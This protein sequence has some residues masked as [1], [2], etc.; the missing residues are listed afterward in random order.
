MSKV[1]INEITLTNIGAAIRERTGKTDLIAPGDMPAEIRGIIGGS[2]PVIQRLEI[3]TNGTYNVYDGVDGF[4]PVVVNVP[5]DGGPPSSAFNISGRSSYRFANGG[6]DWFITQY[7]NQI[8]TNI[9][10]KADHMFDG[11]KVEIP[12][13]INLTG[14]AID[15]QY[16]VS[17]FGGKIAPMI[18]AEY[19]PIDMSYMF[20]L[21]KI[22]SFPEGYGDDWDWSYLETLTGYQGMTSSMFQ[23]CSK[24]KNV[25]EAL[26]SHG[27][28]ALSYNYIYAYGFR[29]CYCLEKVNNLYVYGTMTSNNFNYT[30]DQCERLKDFTFKTQDSG[31]PF[32]ANWKG[33]VIDL[34]T[35]GFGSSEKTYESGGYGPAV[36]V[37]NDMTKYLGYVDD[38][39][40]PNGWAKDASWAVYNRK[41]AVRTINSLPDVS[42]SGGTNT[43]KFKSAAASAVGEEY[44]MANLSEAEIAVAAAKGWT[45][46]LA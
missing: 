22:E 5:Q 33:Q 18:N 20:A 1:S 40:N 2:D 30:F 21:S 26:I 45:V 39:D 17:S 3:T 11:C 15:A 43:I 41:S 27:N 36:Q 25:P 13:V 10:S 14:K 32:T 37:D 4:G 9:S 31:A 19:P 24:L 29:R 38:G 42:A 35:A 12:F 23:Q 28:P 7:G 16:M 6:W 46:T 44:A 8:T 34:T